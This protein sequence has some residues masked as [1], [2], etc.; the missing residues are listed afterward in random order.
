MGHK[1]AGTAIAIGAIV[2]VGAVGL[3]Y[4]SSSGNSSGNNS[5]PTPPPPPSFVINNSTNPTV[6]GGTIL[7]FSVG[8][9]VPGDS[10]NIYA[11]TQA[12]AQTSLVA[13]GKFNAAGTF[14]YTSVAP[15]CNLAK[16]QTCVIPY[17]ATDTTA[18]VSSSTVDLSIYG[19]G[20]GG[21]GTTNPTCVSPDVL[22]TNGT[23]C[24]P[25]MTYNQTTGCCQPTVPGGGGTTCSPPCPTGYY[26]YNNHCLKGQGTLYAVTK[27]AR[28]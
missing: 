15:S 10:V 26:C 5:P 19:T 28:V 27:F 11:Q 16:G 2:V 7:Q 22:P 24:A 3:Y 12:G 14:S 18:K 4:I 9:G 13:S 17:W 20:G 6:N 21:G 23:T 8:G 1:G 25:D